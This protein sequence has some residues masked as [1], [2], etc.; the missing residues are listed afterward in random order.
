MVIAQQ[1]QQQTAPH[2]VVA[3][4]ATIR[5]HR[6]YLTHHLI[7]R[8]RVTQEPIATEVETPEVLSRVGPKLVRLF[9]T[10]Q[11]KLGHLHLSAKMLRNDLRFLTFVTFFFA[12]LGMI[13]KKLPKS[14]TI[15]LSRTV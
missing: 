13:E 10:R 11:L 2:V 12:T 4:A 9:Y 7:L 8:L 1:A 3:I 14:F 15:Y 6:T 5:I